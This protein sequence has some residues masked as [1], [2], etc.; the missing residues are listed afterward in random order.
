MHKCFK[1]RA[2]SFSDHSL[3]PVEDLLLLQYPF[4]I[5]LDLP[6]FFQGLQISGKRIL[7]PADLLV[8]FRYFRIQPIFFQDQLIDVFIGSPLSQLLSVVLCYTV[9]RARFRP[10]LFQLLFP[11]LKLLKLIIGFQT[12]P[13]G[14]SGSKSV[15]LKSCFKM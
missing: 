14:L 3:D 1:S 5:L 8:Q 13:E 12:L 11:V 9:R 7:D 15:F 4:Q 2:V 10:S 6:T